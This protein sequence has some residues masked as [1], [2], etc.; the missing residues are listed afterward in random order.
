MFT[1]ILIPTDGSKLS[2]RAV[3][4]G[5]QLPMYVDS[6]PDKAFHGTVESKIQGRTR[7]AAAPVA[8]RVSAAE[9]TIAARNAVLSSGMPRHFT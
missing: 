4:Q 2:D 9:A 1:S 7:T 6:F 5:L 8:A 3:R